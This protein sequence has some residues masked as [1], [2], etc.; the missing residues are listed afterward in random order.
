MNGACQPRAHELLL[1]YCLTNSVVRLCLQDSEIWFL[2]L[3][4]VQRRE[5]HQSHSRPWWTCCEMWWIESGLFCINSFYLS[6]VFSQD[7]FYL[8][9]KSFR[10][11]GSCI[12][13]MKTGISRNTHYSPSKITPLGSVIFKGLFI[14]KNNICIKNCSA[15]K[16][17]LLGDNLLASTSTGSFN[18]SQVVCNCHHF[19]QIKDELQ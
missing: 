7:N 4:E 8:N 11:I 6:G 2:K 13:W 5:F 12:E 9:R 10:G 17:L 3:S 14:E 18:W 19:Q 16:H 15:S 1:T